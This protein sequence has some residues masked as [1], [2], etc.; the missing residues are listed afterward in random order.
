MPSE[1]YLE[2][3][4]FHFAFSRCVSDLFYYL[5]LLLELN[6]LVNLEIYQMAHIHLQVKV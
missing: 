5:K 3:N 6:E 1:I 4:K 2:P